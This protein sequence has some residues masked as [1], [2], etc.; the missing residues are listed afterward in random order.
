M[1]DFENINP[2]KKDAPFFVRM[3][4]LARY[5]WAREMLRRNSAKSVLDIACADGYGTK[6]L[7]DGDRKVVGADKSVSL[8]Q[9]A[10]LNCRTADFHVIDADEN[11]QALINLSPFTAVCCFETLEHMKYPIRMLELLN[12]CLARNGFL[13][14]SVPNGEFEPVDD[15]GEILSRYHKHVFSDAQLSVMMENCGFRIEQ[16]LHQHLSAQLH[17]NFN[18]TVRDRDTTTG[19]LESFFPREKEKLDLLSEVFAWPDDVKGKSYNMIY[20]C[21][22]V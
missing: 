8:I 19:E 13:M 20:L 12:E 2:Y 21:K 11:E 5:R 18:N 4:H 10:Q 3:E 6:Q 16:K 14:L 1:Y 22:K 9:K 15:N 7:C 17:R